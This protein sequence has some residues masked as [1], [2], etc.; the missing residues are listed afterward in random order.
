M[1]FEEME[2]EL[3]VK[4]LYKDVDAMKHDFLAE[5]HTAKNI[6]SNPSS[7]ESAYYET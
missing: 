1:R 7:L 5:Y 4:Q 3:V 6:L 2:N